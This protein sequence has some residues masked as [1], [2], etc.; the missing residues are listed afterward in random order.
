[1]ICLNFTTSPFLQYTPE[2]NSCQLSNLSPS[3]NRLFLSGESPAP[4]EERLSFPLPN[5]DTSWWCLDSTDGIWCVCSHFWV[6]MCIS[7]IVSPHLIGS[8]LTQVSLLYDS[9]TCHNVVDEA[10]WYLFVAFCN[11]TICWPEPDDWPQLNVSLFRKYPFPLDVSIW[12]SRIA[13]PQV[14]GLLLLTINFYDENDG[15]K[16]RT[17]VKME[18]RSE[19]TYIRL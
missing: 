5:A 7:R 15:M 8:P 9:C 14:I 6:L 11:V 12:R 10:D 16:S 18:R 13:D 1:M 2:H 4:E 17:R 19:Y 3:V